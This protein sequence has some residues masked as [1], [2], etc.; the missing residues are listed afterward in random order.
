LF[1]WLFFPFVFTFVDILIWLHKVNG[2]TLCSEPSCSSDSVKVSVS[3]LREVYFN[4]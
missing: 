3:V 2:Q 4:S 1:V